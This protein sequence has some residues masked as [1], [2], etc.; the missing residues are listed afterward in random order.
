MSMLHMGNHRTPK[1]AVTSPTRRAILQHLQMHGEQSI[2]Q[3][4]DAFKGF[5][6]WRLSA[7]NQV[8]PRANWLDSH[9]SSL[10]A[11]GHVRRRTEITGQVYWSIGAETEAGPAESVEIAESEELEPVQV[12][13]PRHV[14]VMH[15]PVYVPPVSAPARRGAA[16]FRQFPSLM[17]GRRVDYRSGS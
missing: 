10:R 5:T 9:L 1:G 6:T 15:G 3:L 2:E 4:R 14:N 12:V 7:E 17:G 13:A 11:A 8:L 16:D